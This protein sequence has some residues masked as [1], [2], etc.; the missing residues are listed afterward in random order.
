MDAINQR[1]HPTMDENKEV[2]KFRLALHQGWLLTE[3]QPE[4]PYW[5]CCGVKTVQ[6]LK[7]LSLSIYIYICI[8]MLHIHLVSCMIL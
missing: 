1:K 8:C 5:S 3:S 7:P 6:E 4:K 2:I